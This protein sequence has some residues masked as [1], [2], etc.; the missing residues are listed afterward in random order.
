MRILLVEKLLLV[1]VNESVLVIKFLESSVGV[2]CGILVDE[3]VVVVSTGWVRQHEIGLAN[4]AEPAL[5]MDSIVWMLF[6]MPFSSKPLI[7]VFDLRLRG[8]MR[9]A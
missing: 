3:V 2:I 7:G 6:R 5:G 8:L 4:V 9:E 1:L